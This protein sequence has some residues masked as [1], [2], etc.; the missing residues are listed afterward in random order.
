LSSTPI[1][2]ELKRGSWRYASVQGFEL[3]ARSA[4]SHCPCAEPASQPPILLQA[5]LSATTCQ[6]ATSKLYQPWLGSP[7]AAPK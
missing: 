1:S 6:P 7:A 3:A 2:P 5:E 4:S